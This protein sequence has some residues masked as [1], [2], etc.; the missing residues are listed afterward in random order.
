MTGASTVARPPLGIGNTPLDGTA[1]SGTG[2]G[3]SS[4]GAEEATEGAVLA[5]CATGATGVGGT[6]NGGG[7][8]GAAGA[9]GAGGGVLT[10]TGDVGGG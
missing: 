7:T 5:G 10:A 8:T 1:G 2:N 6:G 9:G 3:P 4:T